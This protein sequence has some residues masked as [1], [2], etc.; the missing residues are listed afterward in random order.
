MDPY[1]EP[2]WGD[3]HTALCIGIRSAL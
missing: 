2:R 3:V 1:L